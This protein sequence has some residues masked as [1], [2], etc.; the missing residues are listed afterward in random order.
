MVAAKIASAHECG[1]G[2]RQFASL[3][4]TRIRAARSAGEDAQSTSAVRGYLC[5]E[6]VHRHFL[7]PSAPDDLLAV[8]FELVSPAALH[9]LCTQDLLQPVP[10][11]CAPQDGRRRTSGEC[12]PRDAATSRRSAHLSRSPDSTISSSIDFVETDAIAST[13]EPP[14]AEVRGLPIV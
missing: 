11:E 7:F 3:E 4:A 14:V 12:T 2:K 13:V 6:L 1:R 9:E 5:G 8:L 10:G